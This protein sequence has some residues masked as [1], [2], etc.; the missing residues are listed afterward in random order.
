MIWQTMGWEC[1]SSQWYRVTWK[2]NLKLLYDVHTRWYMPF[3][4]HTAYALSH[5]HGLV[6]HQAVD[7]IFVHSFRDISIAPLQVHYYLEALL[8]TALTVSELTRW[9]ATG[10]Y[11]C[12]IC[13]RSLPGGQSGI[14]TCDPLPASHRTH[15]VL[16]SGLNFEVIGKSLVSISAWPFNLLVCVYILK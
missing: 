13:P 16:R 2:V 11:E 4:V 15:H 9:S 14:R 6:C 7:F 12:R 1:K 8:T 5:T 3:S 10:N